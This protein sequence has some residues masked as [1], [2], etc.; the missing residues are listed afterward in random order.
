MCGN[1]KSLIGSQTFQH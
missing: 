1:E